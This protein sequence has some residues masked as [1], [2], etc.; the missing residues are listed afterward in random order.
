M[1]SPS[2]ATYGA[3]AGTPA[4][5]EVIVTTT[6]TVE[7][8]RV[9][10]DGK[11]YVL[12]PTGSGSYSGDIVLPRVNGTLD[13]VVD[14]V[15]A[16]TSYDTFFVD[17]HGAGLVYENIN[18]SRTPVGGAVVTV[19]VVVDG[20]RVP[21]TGTA[22]PFVVGTSGSFSFYVPN[23][24]YVVNAGKA[25]Y[26]DGTTGEVVVTDNILA[27][28]IAL[29]NQ[30]QKCQTLL[31]R[32]RQCPQPR[33]QQESRRLSQV[34]QAQ[35][36]HSSRRPRCRLLPTLRGPQLRRLQLRRSSYLRRRSTYCR[37]CN[38]CLLH[39][40]YSSRVVVAKHSVWSTMLQ[41][42]FPLTLRLSDFS[43]CRAIAYFVQW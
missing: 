38:I 32:R 16:P 33:R 10:I 39:L 17:A 40:H 18:N 35:L 4:T 28:T 15:E 34:L 11:T 23:G 12:A 21:W 41:Q 24:V 13:V 7:E 31:F 6:A 42:N 43:Q 37:F 1:L 19:Y 20:A 36:P 3:L 2:G 5:V 22:N 25:G 9:D 8:V 26:D 30:Q 27:P 29:K 14:T